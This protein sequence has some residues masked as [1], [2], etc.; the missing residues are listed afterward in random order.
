MKDSRFWP[1]KFILKQVSG[2]MIA[3]A[4]NQAA[5]QKNTLAWPKCLG[6]MV[7]I[8]PGLSGDKYVQLEEGISR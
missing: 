4:D 1:A 2:G 8:T 6:G 7:Q 3:E 5:V